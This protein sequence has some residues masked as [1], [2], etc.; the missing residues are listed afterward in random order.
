MEVTPFIPLN[1]RG[2]L[3]ERI[4]TLR[5]TLKEIGKG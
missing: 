4:L 5:G 2:R 1:L 3:E